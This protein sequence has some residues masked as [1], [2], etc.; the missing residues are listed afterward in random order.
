MNKMYVRNVNDLVF[1]GQ[2]VIMEKG[3]HSVTSPIVM[4]PLDCRCL[5]KG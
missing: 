5:A 2:M 1:T 3:L 4:W